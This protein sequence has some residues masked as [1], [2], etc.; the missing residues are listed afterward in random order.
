MTALLTVGTKVTFG[1]PNGEQ[2]LGTIVKVNPTKYKVRQDEERG[3]LRVRSEGT[4]WGVPFSMVKAVG[5]TSAPAKVAVSAPVAKRSEDAILADI[6]SVYAQLEPERLSCDG[7]LSRTEMARR[8][9]ALRARLRLLEAE[10]GRKVSEDEA[11]G[12]YTKGV[13]VA[14]RR[15]PAYA[16]AKV[17]GFKLGDKVSFQGKGML[18]TGT[19]KRVSAKTISVLP[20]NAINPNAYWRVSPGLLSKVA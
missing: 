9:A 16:P 12:F 13:G 8:G 3:S 19:V 10:I 14:H 4:I 20:V 2:T 5:A 1:R 17:A 6:Q 18:I 15:T 11:Y 7:E